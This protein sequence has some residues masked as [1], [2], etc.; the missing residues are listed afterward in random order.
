MM[1]TVLG[2]TLIPVIIAW[3]AIGCA[4]SLIAAVIWLTHHDATTADAGAVAGTTALV[5]TGPP[6]TGPITGTSS[7]WK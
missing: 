6:W 1:A 2:R 3:L 4:A 5:D 7:L